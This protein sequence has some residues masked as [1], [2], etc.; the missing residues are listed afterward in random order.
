MSKSAPNVELIR[1]IGAELP[2]RDALLQALYEQNKKI[3]TLEDQCNSLTREK[4]QIDDIVDKKSDVIAAQ[5][6]RIEQLEE[7]LRLM[8]RDRYGSRSEKEKNI[9]QQDLFNEAE[10]LSDGEGDADEVDEQADA[11]TQTKKKRP[12]KKGLSPSLARIQTYHTLSD[13]QKQGAIDTF[14]EKTKEELDII[15]AKVRV[16]EHMQE[17]AVFA[18]DNGKRTIV[19]A[20]K[21]AHPLGKAIASMSLLVY[22]IISKYADGLPLY[23]LEG[24]LKRYGGDIT[25]TT[26]ANWLIRLATELQPVINLLEEHQLSSDYLQG[27]ETRIK[28]LKEPGMSP[29]SHKQ[30]WIMRGGPPGQT[31]VLFHYDKS[32]SK[33]VAERLLR[34]FE[35]SYF[36]SDGYAA[37]DAICEAKGIVHL[38]CWDHARP[39]QA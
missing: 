19:S 34:E 23:R 11:S 7:Y 14:F 1:A 12:P 18:D 6:K 27:D 22:I 16:I 8:Q 3:S 4:E 25:R 9:H 21:P 29:T 36:Q 28:V 31:S 37:Y 2:T 17:K 13:E 33:S 39:C 5:K 15:P 24:I 38:G 20:K 26:L 32:R 30:M 10:L 35:G